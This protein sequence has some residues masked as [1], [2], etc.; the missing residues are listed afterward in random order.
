MGRLITPFRD[1]TPDIHPDAFVDRSARIIGD[2]IIDKGVNIWPMA[3][4]WA[5][6]AEI[7]IGMNAAVLDLALIESPA[8]TV[9]PPGTRIPPN[10]LVMGLPGKIVRETTEDE[11]ARILA[12]INELYTKS[13][14][15]KNVD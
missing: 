13:R 2:V 6:S 10:S 4:L 12:Q 7:L 3:V 14:L 8:G 9:V 1:K 11:R 5:D 15:Y